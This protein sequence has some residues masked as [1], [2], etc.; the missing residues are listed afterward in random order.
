MPKG[1]SFSILHV[2]LFIFVL[3]IPLSAHADLFMSVSG[4]VVAAD[5][6]AGLGGVRLLL[7]SQKKGKIREV[8][9]NPQGI[10]I[11]RDVPKGQYEIWPISEDPFVVSSSATLPV[12]VPDGKNVVGI[13]VKLAR[14]GAVRGKVLAGNGIAVPQAAIT[15]SSGPTTT[16]D[17]EGVFMVRGIVPGSLKIGIMPPAIGMRSIETSVREGQV[18]EIGTISFEV[19]PTSAMSGTV[20]DVSGAPISGAILIAHGTSKSVGYGISRDDGYFYI[21]G[22]P[23]DNNYKVSVVAD[24]YQAMSLNDLAVPSAGVSV[25]LTPLTQKTSSVARYRMASLGPGEMYTKMVIPAFF[26][27]DSEGDGRCPGGWWSGVSADF[28]ALL[29]PLGVLKSGGGSASIGRLACWDSPAR[30]D[31]LSLCGE[32]GVSNST[33]SASIGVSGTYCHDACKR[34]VLLNWSHGPVFSAT[35]STN[36]PY[37]GPLFSFGADYN[38]PA[39]CNWISVGFGVGLPT[40]FNFPSDISGVFAGYRACNTKPFNIWEFLFKII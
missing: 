4:K 10:F 5:N 26:G 17:A 8:T 3:I 2:V 33:I 40:T 27:G 28:T 19:G 14:G 39:T 13:Q 35:Q 25:V 32:G 15:T 20:L 11:L 7:M 1:I 30:L 6:G 34:D 31:F 21:T 36:I 24:G 29:V 22:M 9:S 23:A 38:G 18:T 12:T 16:T 37:F